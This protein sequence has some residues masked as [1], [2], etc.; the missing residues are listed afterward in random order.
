VEDNEVNQ[1]VA[2]AILRGRGY[3]VDVVENGLEALDA[4]AHKPYVA[5]LMDCQMPVMDGYEATAELRRRENG[6]EHLPIIAL[7]AHVFDGERDRC[8]AA[9]MDDFLSKPVRA[10]ELAAVLER[11]IG[12]VIDVPTLNS[13]RDAVGGDERLGRIIEVFVSQAETHIETIAHAISLGD[14]GA[15]ARTAHTL[16]G[17]A[18]AIGATAMAAIATELERGDL[19]TAPDDTRRLSAAFE[20]TRAELAIL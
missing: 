15:V 4:V 19:T 13:L 17:G 7:T 1:L 5:V 16:K 12:P 10:D 14:A 8:R 20:R 11:F 3:Q 18:A 2:I 9:G 6:G